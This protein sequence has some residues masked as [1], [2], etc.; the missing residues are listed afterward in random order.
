MGIK[1]P[2]FLQGIELMLLLNPQR[3][4]PK[5]YQIS[6]YENIQRYHLPITH[7]DYHY[8]AKPMGVIRIMSRSN[9]S[10]YQYYQ[11]MASR[12]QVR[13]EYGDELPP[14]YIDIRS[15]RMRT[16]IIIA[17]SDRQHS[18]QAQLLID[19]RDAIQAQKYNN[20]TN[21]EKQLIEAKLDRKRQ[22][23][24]A[25]Q[26]NQN[27]H[28]GLTR[29][30]KC[31]LS[32]CC[33]V[34]YRSDLKEL[35][36][37]KQR[38]E[39]YMEKIKSSITGEESQ[40]VALQKTLTKIDLQVD[41]DMD[42]LKSRLNAITSGL[43]T[44]V[45]DLDVMHN[46][47]LHLTHTI[48]HLITEIEYAHRNISLAEC[49]NKHIPH[50]IIKK[51][52]LRN[53]LFEI[54]Q[55]LINDKVLFELAIPAREVSSYYKLEVAECSFGNDSIFVELT[56]PLKRQREDYT[57]YKVTVQPFIYQG[58]VCHY[59]GMAKYIAVSSTQAIR[60]LNAEDNSDCINNKDRLCLITQ[61]PRHY[62]QETKCI[63]TLIFQSSQ[64]EAIKL[65]NFECHKQ[66]D[67]VITQMDSTH[68]AILNPRET[69]VKATVK[70]QGKR[71]AKKEQVFK[72]GSVG[73]YEMKLL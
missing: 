40:I 28:T 1:K 52:Q 67:P 27:K 55:T 11:T 73:S 2:E 37:S 15:H 38:I 30:R 3:L 70:C 16:G 6:L 68:Y 62:Q 59:E 64:A 58:K 22:L 4:W 36:L 5:E 51:E 63:K 66:E 17:D 7:P 18:P 13:V 9:Y 24:N 31:I 65:C 39:D 48:N 69:P 33:D 60:V 34:M 41:T 14:G 21:Q 20:I 46:T 53:K 26:K 35:H 10:A 72:I 44:E 57:V 49:R 56:V 54:Q 42:I 8:K 45:Q 29:K 71:Q 32:L 25:R 23:S 12:D 47:Q 61:Y 19:D 43:K 50:F